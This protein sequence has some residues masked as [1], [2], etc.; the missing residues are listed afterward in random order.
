MALKSHPTNPH[1]VLIPCATCGE[2]IHAPRSE[3]DS[4]RL[5]HLP[6]GGTRVEPP[7]NPDET[8]CSYACM[9]ALRDS[10]RE[11]GRTWN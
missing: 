5:V 1:G 10:F 8:T 4:T 2:E 3:Y 11:E 9:T 6:G 7:M